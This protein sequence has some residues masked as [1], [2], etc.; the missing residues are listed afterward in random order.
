MATRHIQKKQLQFDALERRETPTGG[1]AHAS[2]G[3]LAVNIQAQR[4]PRALVGALKG[5][6]SGQYTGSTP[7]P[8][9]GIVEQANITGKATAVGKLTGTLTT[10]FAADQL[11]FNSN[12]ILQ[13][14]TG[15]HVVTTLSGAYRPAKTGVERGKGTLTILGGSG[16]FSTATGSGTFSSTLDTSNGAVSLTF[17]GKIRN[18]G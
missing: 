1:L 5:T 7:V 9:G 16:A 10:T 13:T 15:D 18:K 12:V 3:E 14:A 4:A 8:D 17:Q 6:V 11:H 2:L